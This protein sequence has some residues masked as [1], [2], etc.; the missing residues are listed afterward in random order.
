VYSGGDTTACGEWLTVAVPLTDYAVKKVRVYTRAAGNEGIDAVGLDV[1]PVDAYQ[2]N[3]FNQLLTVN[4]SD[5]ST[6]A[7]TYDGNGNQVTKVDA[8]GTTTY[9]YSQDNRLVGIAL[10]SGGSDSF[11]YD[12]NGLRVNKTDSTGPSSYLLDG[13]SVIGQYGPDGSRQAWYTQSLA[14]IDEVLSVVRDQGTGWQGKL[15]YE[16]D[17]LGSVYALAGGSQPV[18]MPGVY[19]PTTGKMGWGPVDF[20]GRLAVQ[21]GYDVFGA[22]TVIA[23]TMGQPFG[24][25]GREWDA[26]GVL[27]YARA[28]FLN[29]EQGRW[30]MPDPIKQRAGPNYYVYA[31]V[32]PTRALDPYGL[33]TEV[34][35]WDPVYHLDQLH[36]AG[37]HVS[38]RVNDMSYSWETNG[39]QGREHVLF[40][41]YLKDN[42]YRDGTGYVFQTSAEEEEKIE[43]FYETADDWYEANRIV[44]LNVYNLFTRNCGQTAQLALRSAGLW[45]SQISMV[46][47]DLGARLASI[48]GVTVRHYYGTSKELTFGEWIRNALNVDAFSRAM[49][50]LDNAFVGGSLDAAAF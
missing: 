16:T 21:A 36:G 34:V 46:P 30:A 45:N 17:A 25:T 8:S 18:Q 7:F 29:P 40:R 32:M 37:G 4:G 19:D 27:I 41:D 35:V 24:F 14:R 13:M 10:P 6:T 15:W 28:R 38:I 12:A 9:A 50:G 5:G 33:E 2:Y 22:Q 31:N 11:A 3:G 43:D 23:G 49:M 44:V 42:D 1:Q 20:N 47:G 39:V 48:P 26:D